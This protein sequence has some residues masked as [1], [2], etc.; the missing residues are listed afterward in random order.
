MQSILVRWDA[1]PARSHRGALTGFKVR[2]RAVGI[3][4]TAGAPAGAARR[5]ADSL[6][7]PADARRAELRGLDTATT[8]QV[9]NSFNQLYKDSFRH[10]K[11]CLVI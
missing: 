6:T 11:S 2:Y 9:D 10:F 8:Y 5:K 7:T 3:S 1:P 4:P